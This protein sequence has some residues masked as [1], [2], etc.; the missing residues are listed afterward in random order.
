VFLGIDEL[1]GVADAIEADTSSTFIARKVTN[2][3][4]PNQTME[5]ANGRM[6]APPRKSVAMSRLSRSPIL[7]HGISENG[8]GQL[9]KRRANSVEQ[10]WIVAP[11]NPE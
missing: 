7:S 9:H 1:I 4:L 6:F 5:V 8:L 11:S 10:G 2:R 3:S